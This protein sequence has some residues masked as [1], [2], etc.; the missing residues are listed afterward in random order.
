MLDRV[1][2][3]EHGKLWITSEEVWF[4]M[5]AVVGRVEPSCECEMKQHTHVRA[6]APQL[7]VVEHSSAR[8]HGVRH[9]T[10]ISV[11]HHAQNSDAPTAHSPGGAQPATIVHG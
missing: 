6:C 1:I 8:S 9:S 4:Q 7:H 10:H 3:P 5:T 11:S 2:P